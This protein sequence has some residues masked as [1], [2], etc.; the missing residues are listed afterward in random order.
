MN[1]QVK[2][3]L[4]DMLGRL[5]KTNH[6]HIARLTATDAGREVAREGIYA[7]IADNKGWDF[8]NAAAAYEQSLTREGND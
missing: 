7:L 1:A 5:D 6:P 3:G 4:D 2:K 8:Y